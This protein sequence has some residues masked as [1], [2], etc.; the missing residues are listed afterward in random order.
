MNVHI[1]GGVWIS[2]LGKA[3]EP[4]LKQLTVSL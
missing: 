4:T 2:F 3:L 1:K